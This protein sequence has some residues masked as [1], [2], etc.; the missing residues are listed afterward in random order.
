MLLDIDLLS[1]D[2]AYRLAFEKRIENLTQAAVD[3]SDVKIPSTETFC[4]PDVEVN[5]IE[6]TV[7]AMLLEDIDFKQ[8]KNIADRFDSENMPAANF[9]RELWAELK[10]RKIFFADD[11][12]ALITKQEAI[13]PNLYSKSIELKNRVSQILQQMKKTEKLMI[14]DLY[15]KMIRRKE[16]L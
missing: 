2:N 8:L 12:K 3:F 5:R 14:Q 11:E 9:N 1:R 4:I 13:F 10:K 7:Q 16:H 15:L 6:N